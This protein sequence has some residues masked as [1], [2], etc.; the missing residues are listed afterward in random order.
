[1]RIVSVSEAAKAINA[2][3]G[4]KAPAEDDPMLLS[5]IVGLLPRIED[6]CNIR[7]LVRAQWRECFRLKY[8][9]ARSDGE[10]IKLRLSN[11]FLDPEVDVIITDPEGTETIVAADDRNDELGVAYLESCETGVYA[12]TDT[13]GFT[14]AEYVP[15]DPALVDPSS[16]D[17]EHPL[18]EGIPDWMKEACFAYL[19]QWFRTAILAPKQPKQPGA[20]ADLTYAIKHEVFSRMYGR[21]L[22]PRIGVQ[23][24]Y[25]TDI[26]A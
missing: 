5:Q 20:A 18:L 14:P 7:S 1:M 23:W 22:R 16:V 13:S 15:T 26:V 3:S 25:K 12:V 8:T 11:G 4:G 2:K 19:V 10:K 6:A 9:A 21:Y 24:P 17:A